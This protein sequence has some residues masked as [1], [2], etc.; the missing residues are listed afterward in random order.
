LAASGVRF[1]G[2]SLKVVASQIR[3]VF[4]REA[5]ANQLPSGLKVIPETVAL[6]PSEH[7]GC[8][9]GGNLAD[10]DRHAIGCRRHTVNVMLVTVSVWQ[11]IPHNYLP[12]P[13]TYIGAGMPFSE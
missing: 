6:S 13:A 8:L 10:P 4:S 11:G 12:L 1:V 7:D 2:C 9:S 5:M 3:V